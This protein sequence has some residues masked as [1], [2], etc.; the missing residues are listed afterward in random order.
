MRRGWSL[1]LLLLLAGCGR[2]GFDEPG[3][4]LPSGKL[5]LSYPAP[6]TYHA[7]VGETAL[8]L[9]PEREGIDAVSVSPPLPAGLSLDATTGKIS[10]T[11]TAEADRVKYT[12]T[13]SGPA[14][15]LTAEI[16]LTALT[17]WKVDALLDRP[18]D[19]GG[20][21]ASCLST[22]AGGCTLRAAVECANQRPGKKKLILLPD[23]L[24]AVNAT[25]TPL[26]NSMVIAG[27]GPSTVLSPNP[28][29][30]SQGLLEYDAAH[31]IRLENLA[32]HNF[33]PLDGSAVSVKNGLFEAFFVEFRDNTSRTSGAVVGLDNARARFENVTFLENEALGNPGWGGVIAGSGLATAV[34]VQG[35]T[36]IAN[37]SIWGSFAYLTMGATLELVNSTL[38]GNQATTAGTLS[39]P[40]GHFRI[41]NS[42][43]VYNSIMGSQSAG[44]YCNGAAATFT[45]GNSIVAHNK[46]GSGVE[47]NC[48]RLN[49]GGTLTSLGGNLLGDD[50]GNCASFFSSTSDVL[51]VDPL[52]VSSSP[53]DAGGPTR[54]MPLQAESRAVGLGV[55]ALC[56]A[57]DQRGLERAL[58]DAGRC[59]SGAYELE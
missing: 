57:R 12:V 43:L 20:S 24:I 58:S 48:D 37:K 2:L 6:A 31:E 34:T 38:V 33:T 1:G 59:D 21:D 9:V 36:A 5:K 19:D 51:D 41:I 23:K 26:T 39:S 7:L 13:G 25:L 42:T 8:S 50:A 49:S 3:A 18:D 30:Q 40:D 16:Y 32:V 47:V 14:G 52:L 56:P 29:G 46:N 27:A 54:T 4:G 53:V 28:V 11:P 45:L 55:G 10:G 17:G 22:E 35:S 15:E 44:L